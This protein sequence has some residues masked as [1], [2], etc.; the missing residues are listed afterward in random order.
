MYEQVVTF[1]CMLR[2]WNAQLDKGNLAHFPTVQENQP[3]DVSMY[4]TFIGDLQVQ[5]NNRFQAMCCQRFQLFATPFEVETAP[6]EL[7]M[8]LTEL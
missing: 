1:Q 2:L 8:E 3:A 7:Q 5:F 6:E 4:A